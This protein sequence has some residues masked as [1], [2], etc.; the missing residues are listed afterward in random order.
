MDIL[1]NT[2]L[3][4]VEEIM[5]INCTFQHDNDPKQMAIVVNQ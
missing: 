2:M 5:L 4:H 3:P 1:N